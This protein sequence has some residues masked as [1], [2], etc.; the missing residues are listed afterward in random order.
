MLEELNQALVAAVY[1][2][3]DSVN[4]ADDLTIVTARR[5]PDSS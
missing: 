2:F 4:Q 1:K 5:V 3:T